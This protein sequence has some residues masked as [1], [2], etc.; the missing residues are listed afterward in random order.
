MKNKE[1]YI[2]VNGEKVNVSEEVYK[3]YMQPVWRDNKMALRGWRCRL[4]NGKRCHDNCDECEFALIG[5]G[6]FGTVGSLN[7]LEEVE[8][9]ALLMEYDLEKEIICKEQLSNIWDEV[10]KMDKSNQV[11]IKMLSDGYSQQEC[12]K[13]LGIGKSA[14][15]QR[16]KTIRKK[17]KKFLI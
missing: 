12:A 13:Y 17:L 6:P 9:P 4:S 7:F 10:S 1:R 14:L 5:E 11:I 8:D 2:Y 16:L 3:A 15:S